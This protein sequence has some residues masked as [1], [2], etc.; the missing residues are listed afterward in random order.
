MVRLG[1]RSFFRSPLDI[2]GHPVESWVIYTWAFGEDITLLLF[3]YRLKSL[4][5]TLFPLK[6]VERFLGSFFLKG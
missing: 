6:L 2:L 1:R 5:N 3:S 4:H